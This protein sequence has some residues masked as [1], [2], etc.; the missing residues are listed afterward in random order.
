MPHDFPLAGATRV[1]SKWRDDPTAGAELKSR[2]VAT[3]VAYADRDDCFVG[4]PPLKALRRSGDALIDELV[5]LLLLG[6]LG[7][8]SSLRHSQGFQVVAAILP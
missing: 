3:E 7:Q 6:G 4:T 8:Q 5:I 1:R 2:L